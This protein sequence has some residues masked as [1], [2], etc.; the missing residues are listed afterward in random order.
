M[1]NTNFGDF[2]RLIETQAR[3]AEEGERARAAHAYMTAAL[4]VVPEGLAIFDN[5]DRLVL[6]NRQYP[7]LYASNAAAM[8]RSTASKTF[9]TPA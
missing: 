4:D 1:I 7:T 2:V 8:V 6:W 9:W 5:E 3:L